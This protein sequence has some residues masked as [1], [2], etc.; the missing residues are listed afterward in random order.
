M[1]ELAKRGTALSNEDEYQGQIAMPV[2]I[3]VQYRA[4]KTRNVNTDELI[5]FMK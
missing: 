2:R 1:R 3:V 5:T 4:A